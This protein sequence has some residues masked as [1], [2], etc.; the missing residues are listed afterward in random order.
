MKKK[1]KKMHYMNNN[2]KNINK[3]MQK[4][5]DNELNVKTC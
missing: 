3:N 5:N 1:L 2:E 4:I